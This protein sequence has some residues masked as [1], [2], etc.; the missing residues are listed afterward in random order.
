[1]LLSYAFLQEFPV[2]HKASLSRLRF[3]ILDSRFSVLDSRFSILDSR[4]SILDSRFSIL[5]SSTLPISAARPCQANSQ[6]TS[7]S[8]KPRFSDQGTPWSAA[9][10]AAP[11][12]P[13]RR[14]D[15]DRLL[16]KT[17]VFTVDPGKNKVN[18][19]SKKNCWWLG[20]TTRNFGHIPAFCWWYCWLSCNNCWLYC[21][22]K[23]ISCR[24]SRVVSKIAYKW[25]KK[26]GGKKRRKSMK[27]R[28]MKK[29]KWFCNY[30]K[31]NM[32]ALDTFQ[33]P[34]IQ[35]A[36]FA[37]PLLGLTVC[38]AQSTR[39][40]AAGS[41]LTNSGSWSVFYGFLRWG[42]PFFFVF[43]VVCLDQDPGH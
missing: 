19:L 5:D 16:R 9:L 27:K 20:K 15:C 17:E 39:A 25:L 4:L 24:S 18:I 40:V 32:M 11:G 8:Q 26:T 7:V 21:W 30:I 10:L 23:A 14:A 43:P 12:R 42:F 31:P 29:K 41:Q 3:S 28:P 33:H 35:L 22:V 37:K 34:S 36:S 2:S 1:M 6:K 13:S 38:P